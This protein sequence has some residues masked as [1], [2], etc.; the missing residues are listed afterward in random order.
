MARK[1]ISI[2]QGGRIDIEY[3]E[4]FYEKLIDKMTKRP[5]P[6]RLQD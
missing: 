6:L 1:H 5:T 4:S 2:P 3:A